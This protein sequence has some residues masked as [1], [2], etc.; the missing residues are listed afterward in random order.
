MWLSWIESVLIFS[1][2]YLAR[3]F[4]NPRRSKKSSGF[5][6]FYKY[7]KMNLC[8]FV[9]WPHSKPEGK[10]I[11]LKRPKLTVF[12]FN[13][14]PNFISEKVKCSQNLICT[15]LLSQEVSVDDFKVTVD[16]VQLLL[17]LFFHNW[18]CSILLLDFI[19]DWFDIL[20]SL[21]LHK[22]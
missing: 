17:I 13:K 18:G 20:M 9:T 11:V 15:Y 14:S 1:A 8:S 4:V 12:A 10:W 7:N 3:W 16:L 19:Y 2:R 21:N 22:Y 6:L 5:I